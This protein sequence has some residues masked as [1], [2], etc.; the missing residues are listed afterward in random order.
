MNLSHFDGNVGGASSHSVCPNS[1]GIFEVVS[2]PE[3][4]WS[5][6]EM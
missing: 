1:N 2:S 4:A 3:P 6:S 5:L